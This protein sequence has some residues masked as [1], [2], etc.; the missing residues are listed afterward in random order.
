MRLKDN[1]NIKAKTYYYYYFYSHHESGF[2]S[3]IQTKVSRPKKH[4]H[5]ITYYVECPEENCNENYAGE[6]G[7]RLSEGVID[8]NG[9]DKNF[10]KFEHFVEREHTPLSLQE[11]SILGGNYCKNKFRRKVADCTANQLT[12]F[13]MR[14]TLAFNKLMYAFLSFISLCRWLMECSTEI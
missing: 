10:H 2:L 11:L 14:A 7:R 1:F 8:H 3:H 12:G 9:R 6:T 5:N 4:Q 13:Y